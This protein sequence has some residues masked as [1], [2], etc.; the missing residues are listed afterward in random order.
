MAKKDGGKAAKWQAETLAVHAGETPCPVTGA[1]AV[2]IYQSSSFVFDDT[3]EAASL[4][5]L[6]EPGFIYSRVTNPT[7]GALEEKIAALE[8]G[9]GATATATGLAA[10]TLALYTVMDSGDDFIASQ[11]LYGGTLSQF[12]DSFSRAFGWT[13]NF[14][15]PGKPENFKKALTE[16]TKAIF[17][18]S[19]SNPESIIPD[20]EAIAKIADAAGIPLIVDNTVA[21][22]Y[23]CRPFEVGASIVTHSTTKYLSGHGHAMGG[24]VVDGG[25]F[26]WMKHKD[27]FPAL[28]GE[29]HGYRGT[30]F[31]RDFPKAPFAMH[32]HGVGLRDLGMTQQP[33]NAWLTLI[34]IETLPLRMKQHSSNAAQVA[35]FLKKHPQ[36]AWVSYAGLKDSPYNAL[37]R[38]YMKDGMCSS[39]FTI[40]LKGGYEAGVR[41][42]E[43]VKIFKHL[44]NIGDT[45]SLIIHPASTTHAQLSDAEKTRAGVG[46]DVVRISVGIEHPADLIADLDQG[47]G[48]SKALA[49]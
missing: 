40:G 21:T 14:V 35:E 46:P 5:S 27:K 49:A 42:V 28:T 23:L 15:D 39:L 37:A 32:N 30:V 48:K 36:V 43:N 3:K 44:A 10:S 13:C 1:S 9:A 20:M 4:F 47:L 41:L 7:V 22:P 33:M 38:R 17:I 29:N 6:K 24:A 25:T 8:G 31:A 19:L 26:D 2:P 16:K 18:E 12:R 34:G 45:K 11:K